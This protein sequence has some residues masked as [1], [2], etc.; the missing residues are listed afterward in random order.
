MR[1]II[2]LSL[3]ALTTVAQGLA[4]TSPLVLQAPADL[5]VGADGKTAIGPL[6][7]TSA[8]GKQVSATLGIAAIENPQ[9]HAVTV[10]TAKFDGA[11]PGKKIVIP[12][13]GKTVVAEITSTAWQPGRN[14]VTLTADYIVVGKFTVAN[15]RPS[16]SDISVPDPEYDIAEGEPNVLK[17]KN[18]SALTFALRWRVVIDQ[19]PSAARDVVLLPGEL[20]HSPLPAI[21]PAWLPSFFRDAKYDGVVELGIAGTQPFVAMKAIP[22]RIRVVRSMLQEIAGILS[23]FF[24]I[25]LGAGLSYVVN[26]AVPNLMKLVSL[27][28]DVSELNRRVN[29][30]SDRIDSRLRVLI[31]VELRRLNV[32]GGRFWSVLLP[33]FTETHAADED[34][35]TALKSRMDHVEALDALRAQYYAL[36]AS[37]LPPKAMFE[38]DA[39]LQSAADLLRQIRPTAGDLENARSTLSEAAIQ[40]KS[41]GTGAEIATELVAEARRLRE[42]LE[43]VDPPELNSILVLVPA[44]ARV[45]LAEDDQHA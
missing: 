17:L 33:S 45:P 38:M 1:H 39:K 42:A 7:L 34:A 19:N 4:Q 18:A 35:L 24:L 10:A 31:A 29:G 28:R 11:A 23:I 21:P 15:L 40:L 5:T 44:V 20:V 25:F 8:N 37:R 26:L 2:L 32:R 6:L 16:L 27:W 9:T 30:V 36:P 43:Q 22:L 14:E 13:A 12:R 41:L 3:A